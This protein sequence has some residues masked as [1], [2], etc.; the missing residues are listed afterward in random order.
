[1]DVSGRRNSSRSARRQPSS[2]NTA[3]GTTVSRM[4]PFRQAAA[5]RD[6][7]RT[8]KAS[9]SDLVI[10]GNRS[11]RFSAVAPIV[12]ADSPTRRS[13]TKRGLNST[14]APIG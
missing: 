4:T 14:S 2:V 1:M 11:W 12:T 6:C 3:I 9:A 13:A 5:A 8:A 10:R 7:D